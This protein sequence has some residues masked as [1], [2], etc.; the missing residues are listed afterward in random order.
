MPELPEVETI[1]RCLEQD[2]TG[3]TIDSVYIKRGSRLLRDTAGATALRRAL[4]GRRIERLSRRGKYLVME[5]DS[6]GGLIVHLGMTGGLFLVKKGSKSP[7]HTH[8]RL[9]LGDQSL[10]MVDPRT[11]G[12]VLV[13]DPGGL[14][15]NIVLSRLGPD[16]FDVSF[17]AKKLEESLKGRRM[18][19]KSALLDQTIAVSG[20]GNIYVD[21]VCFRAGVLPWRESG[22]LSG[23]EC[24]R[25]H[26]SIREVLTEAI[27]FRGTTIRDYR[28]SESEGGDFESKLRVYGRSGKQCR[29]CSG[30]IE[31]SR[32]GGRSTHFCSR[33]QR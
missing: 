2:I 12:K 15:T 20:L 24:D 23:E 18:P 29:C 1:R 11:F 3:R 17:T 25:L 19:L 27:S 16:P 26:S 28:W 31:R 22:R 32:L 8:L 14:E 10:V 13:C 21:E 6:G 30:L 7:E 5:L 33:C 4:S 9:E